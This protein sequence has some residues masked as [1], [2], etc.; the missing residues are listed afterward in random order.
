VVPPSHL[1]DAAHSLRAAVSLVA[2]GGPA[3]QSPHA[4][5]ARP[6]NPLSD[7]PFPG[8][9]DFSQRDCHPA[10]TPRPIIAAL[11]EAV[12]TTFGCHPDVVVHPMWSYGFALIASWASEGCVTGAAD[13]VI[14]SSERRAVDQES[15]C[16]SREPAV[17]DSATASHAGRAVT[18][19]LG[20]SHLLCGVRWP[21]ATCDS[22]ARRATSGRAAPSRS[23]RTSRNSARGIRCWGPRGRRLWS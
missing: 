16:S 15:T 4:S 20:P 7:E 21:P 14:G 13:R 10:V 1:R 2:A 9:S 12:S 6:P 17:L 3:R 22:L 8:S 11:P 18:H 5:G 23:T 19:P